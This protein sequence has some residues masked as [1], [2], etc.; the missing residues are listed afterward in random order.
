MVTKVVMDEYAVH[1][2]EIRV[3]NSSDSHSGGVTVLTKQPVRC[4]SGLE[5]H[6]G[7]PR[8]TVA[9]GDTPVPSG[10]SE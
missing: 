3:G 4:N 5:P 6:T 2:D 9:A 7:P 1:S 8:P 10:R